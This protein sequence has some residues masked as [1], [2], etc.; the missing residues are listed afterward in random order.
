MIWTHCEAK[1]Q[2]ISEWNIGVFQISQNVNRFFWR[3]SALASK[4]GQI[5]NLMA[6]CQAN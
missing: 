5:K 2:L 4:M 3:I 6:H 1:G